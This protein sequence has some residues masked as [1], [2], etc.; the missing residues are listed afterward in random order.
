M[1]FCRAFRPSL[2]GNQ[3]EAAGGLAVVSAL[4]DAQ[5]LL[6]QILNQVQQGKSPQATQN[7]GK[8]VATAAGKGANN[9][10]LA[11][12]LNQVIYSIC[13]I[14]LKEAGRR[15]AGGKVN[16]MQFYISKC[17]TSRSAYVWKSQVAPPAPPGAPPVAITPANLGNSAAV[18]NAVSTGNGSS[19]ANAVNNGQGGMLRRVCSADGMSFKIQRVRVVNS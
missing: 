10:T 4:P 8:A 16:Q 3:Q 1:T 18:A 13:F 2:Q 19:S 9:P 12:A 6:A 15:L 11:N 7:L 5:N 14:I 17:C